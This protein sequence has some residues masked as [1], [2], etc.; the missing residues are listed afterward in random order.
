VRGGRELRPLVERID[1]LQ[2]IIEEPVR[3][4]RRVKRRRLG[5]D[6]WAR[7]HWWR[8][9][10]PGELADIADSGVRFCCDR[11][12]PSG[13]SKGE[14]GWSIGAIYSRGRIGEE[15]RVRA[16]GGDRRLGGVGLGRDS[17][18]G[19]ETTPTGGPP[20]SASDGEKPVPIRFGWILGHGPDL[21]P[22]QIGPQRPFSFSFILFPFSFMFSDLFRSPFANLFQTQSNKLLNS[23]TIH[24]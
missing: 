10:R 14:R 17:C 18:P 9:I 13:G 5:G 20:L 21:W 15:A 1:L 8:R 12:M 16:Q 7:D 22:G 24:H 6:G 2:N 23:S 3:E 19:K 11:S 4:K